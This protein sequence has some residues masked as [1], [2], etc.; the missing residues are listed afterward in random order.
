MKLKKKP[1]LKTQDKSVINLVA[2]NTDKN[3]LQTARESQN[4]K[5]NQI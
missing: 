2:N 5:K 3:R 4:N 1:Q